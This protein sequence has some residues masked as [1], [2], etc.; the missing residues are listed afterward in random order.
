VR[1]L[2]TQA[3]QDD[4]GHIQAGS[5]ALLR[6]IN[7]ILSFAHM[8]R[9]GIEVTIE[10]VDV[11]EAIR[12]AEALVKPRLYEAGLQYNSE[13][14]PAEVAV[15][16]D[17]GRLQQI[18]LNLLTNAIK[19]TPRNGNIT[20]TKSVSEGLVLIQIHDSGHGIAADQLQRIF[21]QVN[22]LQ[23]ESS[24][25]GVGLGLAICRK[26]ARAMGGDVSATSV[27]G[28]GSIFTLSLPHFAAEGDGV[29][30]DDEDTQAI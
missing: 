21:V 11:G 30:L 20:V 25:R 17:A 10:R 28:Q 15:L 23:V 24:Q 1:L 8:D 18:L 3:Q 26:L 7:D 6:L 29:V 4:L 13:V 12:Q 27:L 2:D 9:D 19:F 5:D 16:A 14:E 22:R